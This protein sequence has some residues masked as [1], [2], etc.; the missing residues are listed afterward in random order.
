MASHGS[1]LAAKNSAGSAPG[2]ERAPRH[3]LGL[4]LVGLLL[5]GGLAVAIASYL[6]IHRELTYAATAQNAALARLA[7]TTLSERFERVADLA[8][9]LATRVRFA[10]L[11]ADGDWQA[12]A[13]ILA[14]VPGDFGYVERL[15]LADAQGTLRAD[16][17]PLPGERGRSFADRAW[18]RGVSRE[19]RTYVSPVYERAALP[20]RNV[21]AV[22][23]P[24]RRRDTAAVAGILVLQLSLHSLFDW[25]RDL[26]LGPEATLMLVDPLGQAAY[27]SG[28]PDQAPIA[29]LPAGAAAARLRAGAAGTV[30]L[31]EDAGEAA[32]YAYKGARFDWGV[33][34]REPARAAFAVRDRQLAL[35]QLA[36][37][38][39][40]A[41]AAALVWIAVRA[42]AR[43]RDALLRTR[44]DLARHTERLRILGEIDR[45][46]VAEQP[47]DAIAAAVI[48]PLRE[49]LDVPRAIVNRFD[50]AAGEAEWV[51]AAGRRR[52]HVGAGVRYSL[53]LMGDVAALGRGEPQLVEV[54][55]LP[56]SGETQ[57]LLFSD[58]RY[59][60]V[61]PMIAGGELL[62]A[63][64]FGG[65]EAVF[66][67]EQVAIAQEVATQLAIAT[68]QARLLERV[69][70][71]AGE[72]EARV[73]ERTAE[74]EAAN[75]ELDAFSYS[76]SHDLRAPLR[77]IDGYTRILE[78]DYGAA[79]DAEARRVIGVVRAEA[80]HMGRLIEDLL[81]F[82]RFGRQAVSRQALDMGAL[83]RSVADELRGASGATIALDALPPAQADPLL[84]RQVWINLV[85]NA[86]KYSGKRATPEIRI[87]GKEEP[88]SS[89]YWVR[90]N[91]AGFDMRYADKLF[92]VFQRLHRGDE[93]PGTGVGLA[94]VQRIVARHGGRVW[95][96][97]TPDG[98]ACFWFSLP[99]EG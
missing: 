41:L 13:E 79:L 52:T 33:V 28:V 51:A 61:V 68:V 36:Y 86:L 47:A 37:V 14:S 62:G 17:P 48:R 89:V 85:G 19:W 88:G 55:A 31:E 78:E 64:S 60:K 73:R 27:R 69:R 97:G 91:G 58:V 44:A 93:F 77:G 96:E 5:A 43:R 54:G 26:D 42:A 2:R 4:A 70:G 21:I 65:R 90:D 30:L 38:L 59:Y 72:L 95:A 92:G 56:Q 16:V 6:A 98:G 32:L 87:G 3:Y 80:H 23:T 34:L 24:V 67:P 50:L 99:R 84:M 35:V 11:V 40:A 49:L 25:T 81:A 15:F 57:A 66:P 18:Y 82:S 46:M 63:I 29:A 8:A 10:D 9:S 12:A 71:Q 22:A 76:V 75:K 39:F 1:E 74:L 7:T 83:A 94:I 20:R 53:A 45:A